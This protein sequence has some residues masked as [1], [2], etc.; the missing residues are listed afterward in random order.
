MFSGAALGRS[1]TSPRPL[2][3][4]STD[5]PAWFRYS[6]AHEALAAYAS[7]LALPG[8][9]AAL[10]TLAA[11][12]SSSL[13]GDEVLSV[14]G[15]M[16]RGQPALL[17]LARGGDRMKAR[18]AGQLEGVDSAC[19]RLRWIGYRQADAVGARLARRLRRRFGGG[20]KSLRFTA[21][22]RGGWLAAGLVTRHLPVAVDGSTTRG[23]ALLV[24]VDDCAFSGVAFRRFAAAHNGRPIVFA[25]L[26]AT[27]ALCRALERDEPGVEAVVAGEL[28]PDRGRELLGG[29]YEAWRR[30]FAAILAERPAWIGLTD[31]VC[32]PWN[33]PQ[34]WVLDPVSGRLERGWR[35]LPARRPG[36]EGGA[37]KAG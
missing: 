37:G 21:I 20:P 33:E 6:L 14:K 5:R 32:F 9:E 24:V 35:I 17:V 26:L 4:P 11:A 29:G 16:V 27:A 10:D 19:R 3:K 25:P 1:T 18:L 34:R 12:I 31:F 13:E 15:A 36:A 7:N 23:G 30:R 8:P 2:V 22:P 28:L